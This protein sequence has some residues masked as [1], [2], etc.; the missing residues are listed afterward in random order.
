MYSKILKRS[1]KM[2]STQFN[3]VESKIAPEKQVR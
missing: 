1:N 3:S 2:N